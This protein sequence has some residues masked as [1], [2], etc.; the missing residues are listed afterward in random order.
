MRKKMTVKEI[1]GRKIHKKGGSKGDMEAGA[2]SME[3]S[4]WSTGLEAGTHGS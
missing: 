4:Y 2:R 1:V 3:A